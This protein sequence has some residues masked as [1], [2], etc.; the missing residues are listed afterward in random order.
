MASQE[1]TSRRARIISQHIN[2]IEDVEDLR[3]GTGKNSLTY[4]VREWK[5]VL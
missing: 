1:I 2:S 5:I 3:F 4:K